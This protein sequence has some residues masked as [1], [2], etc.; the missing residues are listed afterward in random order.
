MPVLIFHARRKNTHVFGRTQSWN[1][2]PP[3]PLFIFLFFSH[4]F[5]GKSLVT[6]WPQTISR[7]PRSPRGT[8]ESILARRNEDKRYQTGISTQTMNYKD[9]TCWKALPSWKWECCFQFLQKI[10]VFCPWKFHDVK[11]VT[12][13][14][15]WLVNVKFDATRA[16]VHMRL[17]KYLH[18]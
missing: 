11:Y 12:W 15:H 14:S 6:R 4:F 5:P 2:Q 16:P 9:V 3:R 1:W 18:K 13:A 10:I 8:P 7:S 17:S